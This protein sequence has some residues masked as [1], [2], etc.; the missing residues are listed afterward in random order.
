MRRARQLILVLSAVP[1][2]LGGMALFDP[3]LA[4]PRPTCEPNCGNCPH[5][6]AL[7]VTRR[8]NP[9][10]YFDGYCFNGFCSYTCA[11]QN[12]PPGHN[13]RAQDDDMVPSGGRV[14]MPREARR[15]DRFYP[16]TR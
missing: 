11:T 2:L 8:G 1:L 16:A 12:W 15:E 7:V 10:C 6:C 13:P 9:N 14:A 3:V 4:V 5:A